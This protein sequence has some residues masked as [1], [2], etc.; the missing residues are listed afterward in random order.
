MFAGLQLKSL[1][2]LFSEC[3]C[4]YGLQPQNNFQVWEFKQPEELFIIPVII[5]ITIFIVLWE[6]RT[7]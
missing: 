6:E 2:E 4:C 1:E 3:G 5:I 7:A